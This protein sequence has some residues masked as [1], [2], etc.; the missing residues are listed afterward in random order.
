MPGSD[1]SAE[2]FFWMTSQ[3]KKKS[4]LA[5][6]FRKIFRAEKCAGHGKTNGKGTAK[7]PLL[8]FHLGRNSGALYR[9]STACKERR[10]T[11]RRTEK[12]I[13]VSKYSASIKNPDFRNWISEVLQNRK[14]SY[15]FLL[16]QYKENKKE[17]EDFLQKTDRAAETLAASEKENC[18]LFLLRKSQEIHTI[19][20]KEKRQKNV[21]HPI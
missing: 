3:K 8:Q 16:Q 19:L 6:F 20:M 9:K 14:E 2:P 10:K 7:Q 13:L 12:R 1:I 15:L 4:S 21:C 11:K 18:L 17:L 5:V